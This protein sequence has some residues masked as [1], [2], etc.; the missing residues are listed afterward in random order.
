[1]KKSGLHKQITS[2]FNDV[3]GSQPADGDAMPVQ[4]QSTSL[5]SFQR[6]PA[7]ETAPTSK[8]EV[9]LTMPQTAVPA[10]IKAARPVPIPTKEM[11]AAVRPVRA[12]MKERIARAFG[13]ASSNPRQKKMAVCA[14]LLVLVFA[15]VL[16]L[17]LGGIGGSSSKTANKDTAP[18]E[19]TASD[20]KTTKATWQKPEPLPEKMRD[21]MRPAQLADV[22][23][24][25]EPSQPNALIVR[26]IVFSQDHPSALINNEIVGVGQV[27]NGISIVRIDKSEVEFEMNGK[28][29]T[30]PVQ[31]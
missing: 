8:M 1:M 18:E 17:S 16:V 21:P 12:T 3:P 9:E 13:T 5:K 30:Q 10:Q 15:V 25:G 7:P 31:R 28:R 20:S 23:S 24:D 11:T 6:D 2:I 29:W 27:L 14:G 26:G 19:T 22:R 4:G